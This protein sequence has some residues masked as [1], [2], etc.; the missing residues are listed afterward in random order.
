MI[1]I[2]TSGDQAMVCG[3]IN[4]S[5]CGN[6]LPP[7]HLDSSRRPQDCIRSRYRESRCGSVTFVQRFGS[8]L[9][10]NPHFH[11]LM[12][13]GVYVDADDQPVFVPAPVLSDSDVQQIVQT[14]AHNRG[15]AGRSA[16]RRS[17]AAGRHHGRID[18]RCRGN[19]RARRPATQAGPAR[20]RAGR[21]H[22]PPVLCIKGILPP[23]GHPNRRWQPSL[24]RAALPLRRPTAAGCRS[25]PA[26]RRR[27][28][29]LRPQNTLVRRHHTSGALTPRADRK[30]R[31]TRTP[32]TAQSHSIPR[33]ARPQCQKPQQDRSCPP[34][35]NRSASRPAGPTL[36]TTTRSSTGLGRP[37]RPR[38][39]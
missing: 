37:A 31:R 7:T 15:R 36:T 38:R 10:L 29:R 34:V 14:T 33:R 26:H 25:P 39:H 20:P 27:A 5:F 16:Q 12:L 30:T 21:A 24:V 4:S 6:R 22:R 11:V 3:K 32:S 23:C 13:D 8:A 2:S 35:T 19:R 28:P 18:S 17:P 1:T 9:N